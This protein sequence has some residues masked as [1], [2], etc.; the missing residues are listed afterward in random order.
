MGDGTF[1]PHPVVRADLVPLDLGTARIPIDRTFLRV[2]T[3]FPDLLFHCPPILPFV[4]G[5]AAD[6]R[7]VFVPTQRTLQEFL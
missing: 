7:H 5:S 2:S 6:G 4:T 1:L 3:F